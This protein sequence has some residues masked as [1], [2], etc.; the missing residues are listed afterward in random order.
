MA[1]GSPSRRHA[2]R[3]LFPRVLVLAAGALVLLAVAIEPPE[4]FG[5]TCDRSTSTQTSFPGNR[6]FGYT[7]WHECRRGGTTAVAETEV[8]RR[9]YPW[10]LIESDQC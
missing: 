2:G 1:T 5:G 9:R 8:C 6:T 7:E 3:R 10:D 4:R